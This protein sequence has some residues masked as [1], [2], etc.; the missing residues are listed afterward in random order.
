MGVDVWEKQHSQLKS[1]DGRFSIWR[2]NIINPSGWVWMEAPR[3]LGER[4]KRRDFAC[5]VI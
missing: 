1:G 4:R 5:S 3:G 2:K